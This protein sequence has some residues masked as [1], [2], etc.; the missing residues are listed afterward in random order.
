MTSICK[1]IE[2]SAESPSTSADEQPGFS[3]QSADKK[4]FLLTKIVL[5]QILILNCRLSGRTTRIGQ[6]VS[7]NFII[8]GMPSSRFKQVKFTTPIVLL[9]QTLCVILPE[10]LFFLL[11]LI[12]LVNTIFLA[13]TFSTDFG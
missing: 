13:W 3:G 5:L 8:Q 6:L 10:L 1:I 7:P 11:F 4:Y 9:S 2:N 12:T